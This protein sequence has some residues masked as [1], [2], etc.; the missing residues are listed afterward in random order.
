MDALLLGVAVVL[1]LAVGVQP[2]INAR[3]GNFAGNAAV[4]ALISTVTSTTCLTL[5]VLIT[6]PGLPSWGTLRTGPWWMWTG[7]LIGAVYV[8]VSLN[9]AQRLGATVLVAVVLIGQMIAA[10]LVDHY[11][12]FGLDQQEI[13]P[14]RI[15]GVICLIVGVIL[16]RA[17]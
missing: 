13:S 1:G 7:G 11:G 9:L 6:R 5:Y 3:L 15:L 17:F 12:L 10:I 8:A 2:V 16:I 14:L 4:A